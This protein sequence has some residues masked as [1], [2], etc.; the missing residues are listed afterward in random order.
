L[1]NADAFWLPGAYSGKRGLGAGAGIVADAGMV[2]VSVPIHITENHRPTSA[3]TG[4]CILVDLAS[5]K[6]AAAGDAGRA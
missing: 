5:V 2:I 3:V 4:D 1:K 6:R